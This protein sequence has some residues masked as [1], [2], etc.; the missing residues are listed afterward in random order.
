[1]KTR[2]CANRFGL[3][4]L[5]A[6]A[7]S[8]TAW[9]GELNQLGGLTQDEFRSLSEDLGS[10][11][12]Y[13]GII[14][15]EGLGITGFDIGVGVSSTSLQ[16]RSLWTKAGSDVSGRATV[17]SLRVHKGLPFGLDLGVMY[18]QVPKTGVNLLGGE[19]RWAFIEGGTVS[20]AVA[21]RL[22]ATRAS[23]LD[24]LD[25]NTTSLDLSVSKG[26]AMFTPFAGVGSVHTS[27]KPGD[28]TGLKAE[29]FN[30]LRYFGGV[31]LSLGLLNLAVEADKTGDAASTSLKLGLR[32]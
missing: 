5:M 21:L 25:F 1:M 16:H 12:S 15:A 13:K 4:A 27:S 7:C 28:G 18:S 17:P 23:G 20:P 9:A 24:Q 11:L 19:V 22:G 14:P 2:A 6:L 3:A 30:Q 26:F 10:T 32:F 31:N 8:G 29:S